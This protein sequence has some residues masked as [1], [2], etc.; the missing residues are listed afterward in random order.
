MSTLA[1]LL[2]ELDDPA[3]ESVL[4]QCAEKRASVLGPEHPDTL[5]SRVM[6]LAFLTRKGESE[7]ALADL[8]ATLLL[9]RDI[10]GD[11]H[12]D[13]I[14][15]MKHVAD[16]RLLLG[17]PE[18]SL[19]MATEGIA[20]ARA[21]NP[22]GHVPNSKMLYTLAAAQLALGQFANAEATLLEAHAGLVGSLGE[23]NALAH[24]AQSRLD[25][26]YEAWREAD[27]SRQND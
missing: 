1:N 13:T 23:D 14:E 11:V 24:D 17:D 2:V 9:Q 12:P 5:R 19:A 21:L 16:G 20:H 10:L 25:A 8:E 18:A 6:L 4:R 3:A 7:T 27:P 26:F 22:S 15:S